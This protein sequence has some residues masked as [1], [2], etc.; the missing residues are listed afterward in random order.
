M[1]QSIDRKA[2]WFQHLSPDR[3]PSSLDAAQTWLNLI[4]EAD[5]H[6][7][8]QSALPQGTAAVDVT[9]P[10]DSVAPFTQ[11]PVTQATPVPA[12]S[13]EPAGD[14]GVWTPPENHYAS[15]RTDDGWSLDQW[16]TPLPDPAAIAAAA[17]SCVE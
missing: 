12:F 9:F 11:V 10:D 8:P 16:P 6:F 2:P 1:L 7:V 5:P 4:S 17:W 15:G 14:L 3:W 13:Q